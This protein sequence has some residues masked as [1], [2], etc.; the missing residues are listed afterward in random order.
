MATFDKVFRQEKNG[1]A[2]GPASTSRLS[3]E[4]FMAAFKRMT[5]EVAKPLF[6]DLMRVAKGQGYAATL[7]E[8]Y[9]ENDNPYYGLVFV[10]E[11]G[12]KIG[13]KGHHECI[14]RLK[15][16]WPEQAVEY[17]SCYDMRPGKEGGIVVT[18]SDLSSLNKVFL[19]AQ[20]E[21]FVA[22]SLE[23]REPK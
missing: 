10:P 23:A 4:E 5:V 18:K 6:E 15:G 12:V 20:I 17:T 14:F 22:F 3:R 13:G 19:E 16:T 9:D 1:K 2:A 21:Q 7:Q 11:Q 8:G